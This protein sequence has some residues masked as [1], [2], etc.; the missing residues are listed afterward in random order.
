MPSL[1]SEFQAKVVAAAHRYLARVA[2][3]EDGVLLREQL[4]KKV[5]AWLVAHGIAGGPRWA[6]IMVA[7][8]I[9]EARLARKEAPEAGNPNPQIPTDK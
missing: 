5:D 8:A 9:G 2:A 7:G 1:S 3:G 6:S 4:V